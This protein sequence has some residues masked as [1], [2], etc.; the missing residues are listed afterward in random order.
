M[1][2]NDQLI[3]VNGESLVGRSN[4]AAMETLRRSMS[5]E[6]N[7]RGTI[8]L[9][10]LRVPRHAQQVSFVSLNSEHTPHIFLEYH[11]N[12]E[13]IIPDREHFMGVFCKMFC[14]LFDGYNPSGV[15]TRLLFRKTTSTEV[16]D[17]LR[18]RKC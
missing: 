2:V 11:W 9:V 6:G 15:E 4:H 16:T 10:V 18:S 17:S 7:A 3:A 14:I 8:Q 1:S 12:F 13:L 5:S